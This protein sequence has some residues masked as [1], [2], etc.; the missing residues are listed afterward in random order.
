[1]GGCGDQTELSYIQTHRG[2]DDG[3]EFFGGTASADHVIV[4][5]TGDDGLDW[6]QGFT[7]S[8]TNF[9]VHHFAGSSDDPRGIEADNFSN[10]NDV[11]PRSAPQVANG[12]IV[13]TEAASHDQGVLLRRGTWGALDGL[14]VYNFGSAGVDLR[15]GG[16]AQTGGWPTGLVVQNSC[17]FDN[18]PD[19]PEDVDCE[20]AEPTSDCNDDDGE[21]NFFSEDTE[22]ADAARSNL[23]EDPQ[24]GDFSGAVD[25]SSAP[26][27]SVANSNCQGAFAPSGTDWTEGWTAFPAD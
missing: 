23:V 11:L 4:T 20:L 5:G 14:V 26:D 13:A 25:G 16:W 8:V 3:V 6:D 21:G 2:L 7:G 15:D 10:N 12:T 18:N 24:L 27:Y 9:I 1:V 22:L 19:Y 17:F